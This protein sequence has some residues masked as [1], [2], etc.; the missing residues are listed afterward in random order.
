MSD[1]MES[2]RRKIRGAD[3]LVSVVSTMK[4]LAAA[5]ISQYEEAVRSLDEYA[6][7]LELG[8]SV[9]FRHFKTTPVPEE[10]EETG[11]RSPMIHAVVFGSDQGL[12]GQFND[13]LSDF[14]MSALK[15][16]TGKKS[17]W[18][19]GER[20]HIR[21]EDAGLSPAGLFQ[22]PNSV[23]AITQLVGQILV[24]CETQSAGKGLQVFYIFHNR[25]VPRVVFKP[26]I[27]K[28][29][30]LDNA[31]QRTLS[32]I[33]WPAKQLPEVI[34]SPVETLQSLIR[35]YLFISLYR[36]CAESLASENASRLAAMQRAEKN[37]GE[38]LDDLNRTFQHLRQA[39]IDEELF[40]VISGSEI[41]MGTE[42]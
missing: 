31:W 22:V 40:D 41:L 12:V 33:P 42:K 26:F 39:S 10:N 2:M 4:I 6:R 15:G 17:V 35:E 16:M 36:A 1:S 38:L 8:L 11:T 20:V 14:T 27:Q 34:N 21:L 24:E 32:Q 7:A 29:L 28:L 25:P 9:C 19:V 13:I 18:A 37:I 3:N 23:N 5:N 30:P